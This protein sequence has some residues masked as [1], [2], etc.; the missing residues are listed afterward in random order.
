MK[1][2]EDRFCRLEAILEITRE[3]KPDFENIFLKIFINAL[4]R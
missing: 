1:K 4:Q 2:Y 3:R